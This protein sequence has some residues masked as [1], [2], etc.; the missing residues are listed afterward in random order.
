M[1]APSLAVGRVE[2]CPADCI[3]LRRSLLDGLESAGHAMD[4][5]DEPYS[6]MMGHAGAV[7]LHPNGICEGAHHRRADGGAAGVYEYEHTRTS[8]G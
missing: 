6:D 7:V 2:A 8:F 5:L 1:L 4:V 3:W